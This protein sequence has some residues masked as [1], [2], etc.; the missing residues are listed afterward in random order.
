[1]ASFASTAHVVDVGGRGFGPDANEVYEE[2]IFIPIMRFADA[3]EVDAGLLNL[4]R[5]NVR[6]ADQVV[7]DLYSLA[8]CNATGHRRLMAMMDEFGIGTLDPL[9]D[10][11]FENSLAAT[12]ERL[13]NLPAGRCTN[14]MVTD[15]YGEPVRIA[16]AL[17]VSGDGIHA[18]FTGT[19][20]PSPRGINVPL[21]Y[22][23]AYCC[24]ALKCALAPDIPN[25]HASLAPFTIGAPEGTIVNAVHPAAVSVRH[26]I[27]H[28]IPDTVLGA[29]AKL[30]PDRIPAEG[31]SS[32]WN[33]HISVRP[34]PGQAEGR[35][36]EILMFNSG[37]TGARPGLD[38]L[39]TTAFPSGV[40]TMPVE[41]TEHT[42]PIL[43][44]RK[45]FREGSGGEGTHRGGLG[46]VIEIQA[47]PGHDFHFNAMFDRVD[48]PARGRQGGRA[49][50]PGG[51]RLDDGTALKAKG[52]Q[53]VPG[54]RRL[55][56]ELPGGGGF[57]DPSARDPALAEQDRRRGYVA[58]RLADDGGRS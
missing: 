38:G 56:L 14:E 39:D 19:S 9:R 21:V 46:Q 27:G 58:P 32:L 51:V 4:V 47:M 10:F 18:D 57:G 25:N 34:R 45:E 20:G 36:A 42:G 22:T 13:R 7:G 35:S 40:M 50:A 44:W 37:G 24:Y 52:R 5:H 48:H 43:I 15:G 31:A 41:A 12:L 30:L 26:V 11:I 29:L 6:E 17:D 8:A 54:D 1:M 33:I 49:G 16:V 55:V 2:G 3:G 23:K 28:M 53:F